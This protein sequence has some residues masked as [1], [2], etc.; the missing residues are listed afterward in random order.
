MVYDIV[1]ETILRFTYFPNDHPCTTGYAMAHEAQS[2]HITQVTVLIAGRPYLL[3]INTAD[4]ALIYR[5]AKEIN[6]KVAAFQDSQPSRDLQDCSALVLLTYAL[7]LHR[8][9]TRPQPTLHV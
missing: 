3:H 1:S 5:L 9:T 6:D 8:A 2:N 7:E 4:E